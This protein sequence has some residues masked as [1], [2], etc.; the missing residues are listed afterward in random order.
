MPKCESYESRKNRLYGTWLNPKYQDDE[1]DNQHP[2]L[3]QRKVQ[4]P[5]VE[6]P[7]GTSVPKW[8][9]PKSNYI[10]YG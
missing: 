6:I 3:E 2:S 9:E 10:R 1:I 7:I 5:W 4:R 8:R